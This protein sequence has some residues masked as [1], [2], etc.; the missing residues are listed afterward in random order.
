MADTPA[1]RALTAST[2]ALVV[3]VAC[4]A[5][6][7]PPLL[8]DTLQSPLRIVAVALV[9]AVAVLLHWAYVAIA[10]FRLGRSVAGWTALSVALFPVGSVAALVLLGW[11]HDEADVPAA[12]T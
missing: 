8:A 9:L 10:A 5:T 11:F 2:A 3:A 1:Q 4:L 12:A 7:L 6:F